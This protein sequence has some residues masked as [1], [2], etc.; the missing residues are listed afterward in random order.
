[1]RERDF[2]DPH[3]RRGPALGGGAVIVIRRRL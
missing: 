2:A 3:E 1:M